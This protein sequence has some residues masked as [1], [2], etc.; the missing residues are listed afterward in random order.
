MGSLWNRS[1]TVE[2]FA[3]DL[4]AR[5]AQAFFYL[6][7]TTTPLTVYQDS[8][9]AA[10]HPHPVLADA[11]GR[12]PDIFVPYI[13]SYD[14]QVKSA[15]GVQ[16][17][18]SQKIPNPDPVELSVTIDP[19]E[20]VSTG[21]IHCELVN[22]TKPGYVR[23]NGK[24]MGNAVSSATERA[25]S[26]TQPLFIYL[27][28]NTTD[29]VAPVSGGRGASAAADFA[30]NKTIVLPSLQGAVP[31]GL[32]DMGAPAGG[33][34]SGLAFIA[35]DAVTP[36]SK[37]G[38]N[39]RVLTQNNLPAHAHSGTS[40]ADGSHAHGGAS[41]GQSQGHTHPIT[42]DAGGTHQHDAFIG[43]DGHFHSITFLS[44]SGG[45]VAQ[46]GAGV[47]A[48][49]LQQN[50][51][52]KTTGVKVRSTPGNAATADQKTAS[53]GSHAHPASSG[54]PSGDHTHAI[55]PDGVHSHTFTTNTIGASEAFNNIPRALLVTWFIKL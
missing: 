33:F 21:M 25:N 53:A 39:S 50:T 23:L 14:V 43:D 8:D 12:W 9:E 24:T 46:A 16:L 2:R 7:G 37:T 42:V 55:S 20:K 6:G 4:R 10:A 45:G 47:A 40:S 3:D 48:N 1:G 11:D 15:E 30:S 34:Y 13:T 49:N 54:A 41:G 17:T 36:A 27:W 35:G 5:G 18:F 38:E 26:D 51:D 31:I 44:S 22:T 32:D 52:T 19:L 29:A 28:N